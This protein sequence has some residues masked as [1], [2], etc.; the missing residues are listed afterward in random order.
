MMKSRITELL[1]IKYPV[2]QGAMAWLATAELAAA[3]SNGGGLGII[4][5][6]N[7]PGAWVREQITKARTLTTKPFGVNVMM[8]S[9]YADEVIQIIIEEKIPVITT[10]AGNPGKYLPA[11]KDAQIKVI[12]V[13]NSVSL[14]KRLEKAGV[15]AIVGEGMEAGGHVGTETTMVLIPQLAD[16]LEVPVI[17]AGGIAD[18][19]GM[20]AAM[21]LGAEGVQ[22]GTRFV[23]AEECIVHDDYKK[24]VL[25]AVDRSTVLTGQS[26]GHP[27]RVI[28][29]K[30][31]RKFLAA[32][33]E[34]ASPSE[35]EA[36][37]AGGLAA[38]FRGDVEE[39][40]VMAGQSAA[41]VHR[42]EPAA[43]IIEDLIAKC[44]ELL[45]DC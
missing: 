29:N 12:P 2:I 6:G 42:I 16:A 3:V 40:S 18:G 11:L 36:L 21:L 8:L 34:G 20:A 31:A 35:L 15:D 44:R 30:L 4:A 41:L 38:A 25:K 33:A 45:G 26:T 22:V 5:A 28:K 27:V 23:C 24:M 9:P 32:E 17:A 39:G 19:R 14:A 37:G 10:G 1:G 13:V 43:A 7:A